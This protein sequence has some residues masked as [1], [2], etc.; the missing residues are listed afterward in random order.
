MDLFD[1]RIKRV[2]D[3]Y[4]AGVEIEWTRMDRHP[5]E[6]AITKRILKEYLPSPPAKILDLGGGPGKY[7]FELSR[8]GYEVALMDLSPANIRFAQEK[9]STAAFPIHEV[10]IHDASQP[11]PHPPDTF[12]AVLLMGPLYHL[13]EDEQR[14]T[15]VKN[16]LHVLK[17]GGILFATFITLMGALRAVIINDPN[18]LER[19]WLT[20]EHGLNGADL[21]FTEA[22]FARIPEIETLMQSAGCECLEMIGCE[23]FSVI[24]EE[25]FL[26]TD[27]NE[28]TWQKWVDLNLEF[29]RHRTALEASD[30]ILYV[31]RKP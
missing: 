10:R 4:D 19:E 5:V 7:A 18:Q 12:D 2:Q 17:P 30:H 25:H 15:A 8:Q 20:M 9:N 3:F 6:F 21:G 14:Q 1:P 27:M 16:A 24:I 22:Y 31:A 23:G 11:L 26:Q 28:K 13:T 29:G